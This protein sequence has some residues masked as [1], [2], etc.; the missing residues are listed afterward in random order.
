MK[1]LPLW[2]ALSFA[3]T[4]AFAEQPQQ[5]AAQQPSEQSEISNGAV[6]NPDGLRPQA[7]SSAPLPPPIP[8]KK[9]AV[10]EA[11]PFN[12]EEVRQIRD[13]LARRRK[14]MAT[15]AP[16]EK[17]GSEAVRLSPGSAPPLV[18]VT[19]NHGCIMTFVD[20]TGQPWTVLDIVN[21][22]DPKV[23]ELKKVG[24][25]SNII[26]INAL[27]DYATGNAGVVL[28]G[29]KTPVPISILSG[30][31]VVDSRREL[32]IPGR[33][34]NAI[35]AVGG[36]VEP[37]VPPELISFLDGIP[38][39]GSQSVKVSLPGIQA[40][41]WNR[42]LVIRT[43]LPILNASRYHVQSGEEMHAY[44]LDPTPVLTVSDR[45]NISM[46]QVGE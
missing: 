36:T 33:G 4:S 1:T 40:W 35:A 34:P 25:P 23:I 27:T 41:S 45:G 43:G 39:A 7:Q 26:S 38:V 11:Y 20:S 24:A 3:C 10:E 32:R 15:P 17:Q 46:V 37:G 22:S 29:L 42:Q 13:E 21:F 44:L 14:A 6:K 19:P 8:L 18:R 31:K 2:I 5:S 30:Q 16:I 28:E 9:L 12:S